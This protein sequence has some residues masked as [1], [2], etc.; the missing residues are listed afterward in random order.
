MMNISAARLAELEDTETKMQALEAGGV[1]NWEGHSESLKGYFKAK[2]QYEIIRDEIIQDAICT[3]LEVL[4]SAAYEPSEPGAGVTFH[5]EAE[6]EVDA[7]IRVMIKELK[8]E[9][10]A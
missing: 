2:E 6:V 8:E 1:V 3:I 9:S 10:D 4:G 5:P 7:A